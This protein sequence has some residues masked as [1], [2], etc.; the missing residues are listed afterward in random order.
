MLLPLDSHFE[1]TDPTTVAGIKFLQHSHLDRWIS[2]VRLVRYI[3]KRTL[4]Q[5]DDRMAVEQGTIVVVPAGI[6]RAMIEK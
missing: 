2:A 4:G 6:P 5:Y 1:C 3:H